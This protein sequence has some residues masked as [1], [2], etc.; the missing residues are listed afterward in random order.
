MRRNLLEEL[1]GSMSES[2]SEEELQSHLSILDELREEA[3]LRINVTPREDGFQV[4]L[5]SFDAP[6]LFSFIT[7]GLGAA[8][9]NL[10]SGHVYTTSGTPSLIFDTFYGEAEYE[11]EPDQWARETRE[12]LYRLLAPLQEPG[13]SLKAHSVTLDRCR[14]NVIEAVAEVASARTPVEQQLM[15]IDVTFSRLDSGFTRLEVASQDTPF[16]LYGFSTALNLHQISIYHVEIETVDSLIRDTFDVKDFSGKPLSDEKEDR[17][18]LAAVLTKQFTHV[19][20]RAPDPLA[21]LKR[22]E[23]LIQEYAAAGD[24]EAVQELLADTS[25]QR[26]LARLLGASDFLWE[27]FI[28]LQQENLL[29]LLSQVEEHRLL[30]TDSE[31]VTEKLREAIDSERSQEGKKRALNS[32]KDQEAFLIDIDHILQR[33]R[34]FF[35]LSHRLTRL[36]EAV[37]QSAVEIAWEGLTKR[38]GT[39]RSA[40]GMPAQWAAFGLGKLGG[41]ALGYASDIEL[42]FLYSDH[43]ETDG[44]EAIP[45]REFFERLFKE[46]TSLIE[47]RRE[48]IFQVDVRLR[49]FGN[50]GPLA[51]HVENFISYYSKAGGSHSVERLALVRL[52]AIAGSRE[53]GERV[54]KIRDSLVYETEAINVAEIRE[55]REKQ[56]SEKLDAGS[57]NAKFSAGALVDLEYNVQLLQILHG[58][59]HPELRNPGIHATLRGLSQ[60]GTIDEDEAEGMIRA[61][62]FLRNLINGLRM[63]RGNAQDLFLPEY[64]TLEFRHLARRMGYEE[65]RGVSAEERLWLDFETETARVRSFVERHLGR[66]AIPGTAAGNPADIVLSES[67]AEEAGVLTH[68]GFEDPER[69]VMNLK[70]IAGEGESRE[71]FASLIVLA[72]EHLL[73]TSDPDMALNNWERFTKQVGD[74]A[75]F[76][77]ELLSQPRRLELMLKVFAGSQFLSDTL[78]QNPSFLS[79]IADPKALHR[80]RDQRAMEAELRDSGAPESRREWLNRLRSFRKRE[81]LRIGTKDICLGQDFLEVVTEISALARAIISAAFDEIVAGLE[82]PEQAAAKNMSILAFGKL[83][84]RELNYSSDIDLLLAYEPEGER[85]NDLEARTGAKI[86]QRLVRDLTDF[87]DQGKAYRVDLRLRP[88]GDSGEVINTVD[89]LLTYYGKSAGL[90][91]LQALIKLSPVAGNIELGWSFLERTK[92]LFVERIKAAGGRDVVVRNIREMRSKAVQQYRSDAPDVK[93]GVG[94]IRDIEFIAQALQMVHARYYPE[95]L[96]GNTIMA[97]SKLEEGGVLDHE[98]VTQ[99]KS[100]YVF[101]R[102]IEHFLQ[103]YEDRQ[104]HTIPGDP[105]ARRKLAR[106]VLGP[107]EDLGRFSERLDEVLRRVRGFYDQLL[108]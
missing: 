24:G 79:W 97:L 60:V 70:S 50:D 16:F 53:L 69:G 43:G 51:V 102:R 2:F 67:L 54:M 32:F 86:L 28:R 88:Y 21:A 6:G 105:G 66:E 98:T 61:Y 91:E 58:R 13:R 25:R 92:P 49:P 33:E 22:F 18:R 44:G 82:P 17:V 34:N 64:G 36:A 103:V 1:P 84:G 71:L 48:G 57:F 104:L 35:F 99:L 107:E 96:T 27:D 72:W 8:G 56:L 73:N 65:E 93:N 83:G 89:Q 5:Y 42:L 52:R 47:A 80:R 106:L 3:P 38:Y 4:D 10:T 75:G 7:G 41:S 31:E 81:I 78:I 74:R 14:Q 23:Q 55:L 39:P 90:W 19:L 100:D 45:N 11:G 29:P 12:L 77:R 62:R 59:T 85:R 20:D 94:G 87:T 40:A 63:L 15:P 76:F 108:Q 30:S 26:E 68:A 37:V 9:L 46:A 101:L 95:A